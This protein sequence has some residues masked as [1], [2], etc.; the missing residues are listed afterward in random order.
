MRGRFSGV[1]WPPRRIPAIAAKASRHEARSCVCR[2]RAIAFAVAGL[3]CHTQIVLPAHALRLR[4]AYDGACTFVVLT[5]EF[6]ACGDLNPRPRTAGDP[7]DIF[8]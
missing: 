5:T 7:P 2:K 1:S 6:R 3:S 4:S 8:P